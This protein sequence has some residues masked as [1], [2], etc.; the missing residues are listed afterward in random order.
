MSDKSTIIEKFLALARE[1]ERI[2][3]EEF[4]Q[5][6]DPS[7]DAVLN[8]VLAHPEDKSLNTVYTKL[9]AKLEPER[10][11]ALRKS[12]R[13]NGQKSA[14]ILI[15]I[16]CPQKPFTRSVPRQSTRRNHRKDTFL[17]LFDRVLFLSC[18]AA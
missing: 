1:A 15:L 9:V 12:E 2:D 10:L 4:E 8:F 13:L 5:P 7:F 14:I 11:E 16:T 17:P 6:L 3:M 18:G